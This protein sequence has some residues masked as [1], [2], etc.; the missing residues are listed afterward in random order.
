MNRVDACY[1]PA[2]AKASMPDA[3]AALVCSLIKN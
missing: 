3:A 2:V 1:I